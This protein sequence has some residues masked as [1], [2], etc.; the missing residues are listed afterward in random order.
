MNTGPC[1]NICKVVPVVNYDITAFRLSGGCSSFELHRGK[2]VDAIGLEPTKEF[3]SMPTYQAGPLPF[4]SY[5]NWYGYGELN[6]DL[7]IESQRSYP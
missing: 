2:L 5:V 4:W 1:L 6:S 7:L 3:C